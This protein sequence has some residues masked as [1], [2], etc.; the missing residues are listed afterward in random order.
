MTAQPL[1]EDTRLQRMEQATLWLQRMHADTADERVVE[2]WLD[3]CTRDPLNQQAFDE[4]AA[5]WEL[6]GKLAQVPEAAAPVSTRS[7]RQ[8]LVASMAALGAAVA[9]SA[10][11]F[12][13]GADEVLLSELSSPVGRNS[14]HTLADGSVLELGGGT[15]VTVAIGARARRVALHAGE[16]Y[17]SVHHDSARPF[18]VIVDKLQVIATGTAF[19][20]LRTLAH[21]TVTVAE[22]S[23]KALYEDQGIAA[24]NVHVQSG[25]QLVHT[26]AT[27]SL[28][29][30]QADPRNV[31]AW[32]TGW[33]SFDN[34]PLGEVIETVNRYAA[35]RLVIEDARVQALTL[36]GTAHIDR[37]EKWVQGLPHALQV[38]VTQR[39]DGSRLI[40][41]RSGRRSD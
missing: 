14:T 34:E 17:V 11:W 40:G 12:N 15:R 25:Q 1:F 4:I 29:V 6:S 16:L 20:V 9:G 22:G 36:T 38:V 10:W 21:T 5:V 32:R 35:R 30:R 39:P 33:L 41:P 37:I 19:N 2:A 3:W 28:V 18:S 23:V 26:Q 7:R 13:R 27:G 24:P 31:T 8:V